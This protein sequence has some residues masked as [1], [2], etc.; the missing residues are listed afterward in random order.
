MASKNRRKKGISSQTSE[1]V[2]EKSDNAKEKPSISVTG[3]KLW[4]FRVLAIIVVPVILFLLLEAGLRLVGFG[5]PTSLAIR[6]KDEKFDSYYSN[7]KFSWLFFEPRIARTIDPFMFP[8]KKSDKTYRIFVMGSSAAAGTPDGAYSFGRIM[9]VMLRQQYPETNFEVITAAMPAINSHAV[10]K[11]AKD[12]AG[13]EPDLFVLYMGNNEVVGPYGAGTVFA[14]L[15]D[16]LSLIRFGIALKSLR[17]GQLLTS[18]TGMIGSD[19]PRV[20]TGM[21]MFLDKQVSKDSPQMKIVYRNFRQNLIDIFQ[22]AEKNNIPLIC[23]TVGSNLKDNPPF[24]SKHSLGLK[25]SEKQQWD[26]LYNEGISFENKG[27][28]SSAAEIYLKAAQI[29]PN[30]AELQ[31]RIGHCYWQI[32]KYEESKERYVKAREQD[33][34]RFRADNQINAI[35]RDAADN[36]SD[37]GI[38][39][40]DAC[41]VFEANSPHDT[42][43]K[44]LFHEHVHLKF[45]GNYL[46]AKTVFDQVDK[47]LPERIKQN[48]PAENEVENIK[49][50]SFPSEQEVAKYLAYTEWEKVSLSEKVLEEYLKQPPFTNQLYNNERIR[51]NEERMKVLKEAFTEDVMK[52]IERQ[53]VWAIK[54]TPSDP[55]LYWKYGLLLESQENVSSAALQ[56]EMVINMEPTHHDAYA[57]LGLCYGYMKNPDK[58]IEYNLKAIKLYPY[59]AVVYYNMGIAYHLKQMYDKATEN[60]KKS[61]DLN[62]KQGDVYYNY[63]LLFYEQRKLQDAIELLESG[64]KYL[65]D[66]AELHYGLAIMLNAQGLKL[67][68]VNELRETLKINPNHKEALEA[69]KPLLN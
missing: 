64:L 56:Y 65:P 19:S 30:Y 45:K 23:S 59:Y 4:L 5:Y 10:L 29:D 39:L 32:G 36:K 37:K 14:Q 1:P 3:W 66:D 24:A 13:Y 31:Y 33:T 28:Y 42:P 18:L 52:E 58:A 20:W 54:Q 38:Y 53:N 44:E 67:E 40:V 27:D 8:V 60:Y 22:V 43:G 7:I 68:A 26:E 57:K 34:L 25:D 47:I 17:V 48:K 21:E 6:Y 51:Q 55:W 50:K 15:S 41:K 9:Q 62:P 61:I 35:I 16:N 12:C 49:E 11:I 2:E 69:L 46:L 63:A